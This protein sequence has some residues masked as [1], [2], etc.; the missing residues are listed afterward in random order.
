MGGVHEGEGVEWMENVRE[1]M[2]NVRASV[3]SV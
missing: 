2:E 3:W 1:W